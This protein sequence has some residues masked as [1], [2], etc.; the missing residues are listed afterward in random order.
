MKRFHVFLAASLIANA[1]LVAMFLARAKTRAEHAADSTRTT[2]A[3]VTGREKSKSAV[4]GDDGAEYEKWSSLAAGDLKEVAA[5]LRAG[6]ISQRYLRAI[7]TALVREH[8]ADRHKAIVDAMATKPWWRGLPTESLLADPKIAEMS[9]KLRNEERD[10]LNSLVG[11]ETYQ[12]EYDRAWAQQRYGDMS[13]EKIAQLRRITFDYADLM[14]EIRAQSRDI[15]L[16]EDREKLAFLENERTR[17]IAKLLT[18]EEQLAM[19]ART[20]PTAKRVRNLLAAFDP[21]EAEYLAIY[22]IQQAVDAQFGNGRVQNLTQEER[23]QRKAM[24]ASTDDQV[25]AVLTPER[26]AEYQLK[27]DPAYATTNDLVTRLALPAT[28]TAQV[29]ATQKDATARVAAI[30]ANRS[31]SPEDKSAQFASLAQE[32]SGKLSTTLG[33]AGVAAY[34]QS[35]ATWLTN[36]EQR[37]RPVVAPKR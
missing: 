10:L 2:E 14:A 23:K 34:K 26:F 29:I 16:P 15:I 8:F 5:R 3:T 9:R 4:A 30:A 35:G 31:L 18:P 25:R 19:D 32:V 20:G 36:L 22:K 27:T 11:V 33:A 13:P 12:S 6:G 1:A 7:M 37:A 24:A 17:D 28:A 21:S